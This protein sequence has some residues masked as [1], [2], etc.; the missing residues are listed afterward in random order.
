MKTNKNL[1]LTSLILGVL[2]VVSMSGLISAVANEGETSQNGEMSSMS[3]GGGNCGGGQQPAPKNCELTITNPTQGQW[4]D[5]EAV[6]INWTLSEGCIPVN[7]FLIQ[8][9]KGS[10]DPQGGWHSIATV[11]SGSAGNPNFPNYH[12]N[13]N[14]PLESGQYCI[15]VKVTCANQWNVSKMFNVDLAKPVVSLSVGKE[16]IGECEESQTGNCYVNS[17]TPITLTCADNVPVAPWQSGVNHIEYRYNVNGG[18]FT[19]WKTLQGASGIFKFPEDSNHVLEYKCIDN[20]GKIS[21]VKS[22]VFI[23]DTQAPVIS[24][25]VGEPQICEGEECTIYMNTNTQICISAVDPEPHPIGLKDKTLSCEYY[26]SSEKDN[27]GNLKNPIKKTITLDKNGCFNYKEDSYH[28]L[29][30]TAVDR[31]GNKGEMTWFDVVDTKAPTTNLK[32]EGPYHETKDTDQICTWEKVK[33]KKCTKYGWVGCSKQIYVW[34]W[35]KICKTV[36]TKIKYIDGVSTVKLTAEDSKP[37]P[38]GV[39]K[40]YYRYSIVDN[41]YCEGAKWTGNLGEQE[42]YV[43]SK[44]FSMDE[45]CHII[46]YYSIDKLGNKE[47]V[48]NE[49]VFVDKTPPET[50]KEVG[51]PS[52]EVNYEPEENWYQNPGQNIEWEVTLDTPITLSC[53]DIG[54]HPSGIKGLYYRVVW[55]GKYNDSSAGW[56]YVEGETATI[57]LNF[58]E[59]CEHLLEFY[60]VDNVNK[61]S[62]IDSE[63]FKVNGKAFDLTIGE[64]WDLISFPFYLLDNDPES[65]FSDVDELEGIWTYENGEWKVY[66]PNGPN[67]LGTIKPG[68]GYW[69]KAK[70]DITLLIGGSLFKAGPFTMPQRNLEKGWNLIGHYGHEKLT[71]TDALTGLDWIK[72]TLLEYNPDQYAQD[73]FAPVE[74]NP[75]RGYWVALDK[76]GTYYPYVGT[77]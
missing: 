19:E 45:S 62:N 72:G 67:N 23:V 35:K 31:L 30:C 63:L 21:E 42:W 36:T 74:M 14:R 75:G 22:K 16:N 12:Y 9:Q 65:V 58:H 11:D 10:C 43:Y 60:C 50:I 33:V 47:S 28:T 54:P 34:E 15:Y 13:W 26:Y 56:T 73:F 40:T 17:K 59:K 38:V 64:K 4:F 61:T 69:V 71:P 51:E 24:R 5:S 49:F 44:P 6:E 68:Y 46:E 32:F 29:K 76:A 8:Y 3:C 53:G 25:T 37:H 48:K 52:K 1:I 7:E 27:K 77:I 55:D 20:V 41:K 70:K 57:T 66:T 18:E 2:I 39:D